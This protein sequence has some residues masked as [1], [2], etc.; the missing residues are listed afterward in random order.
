MTLS[1]LNNNLTL[2]LK[3]YIKERG[4]VESGKLL[5]SVKFKCTYQNDALVIKLDV[6]EYFQ[7]LDDG[8][9][10]SK[11]L[12]RQKQLDVIQIFYSVQISAEL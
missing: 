10:L 11:F 9:L 3:S 1:E 5:N 7:Y 6:L 4:Y 8:K 2:S 12:A